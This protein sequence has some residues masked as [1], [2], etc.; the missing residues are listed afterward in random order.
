EF[1]VVTPLAA[2][3]LPAGADPLHGALV[4][5]LAVGLHCVNTAELRPGAD[6]LVVGAGTVGLTTLAWA[7]TRGAGRITVVDPA[8]ARRAAAETFGATDVLA[9]VDEA[10]LGRYHVVVECVGKPGL[11]DAC[12]NAA[13]VRG[14][15]VIAGVCLEP[16]PLSSM[17]ALIK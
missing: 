8:A 12:V 11:L 10:E 9:S 6:V 13:R 14:R 1:A 15:V 16:T 7:R 4:E 3:P 17:V 2:F 5:P